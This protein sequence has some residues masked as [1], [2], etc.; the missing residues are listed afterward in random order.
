M[1]LIISAAAIAVLLSVICVVPAN[2]QAEA[3]SI[4]GVVSDSSGNLIPGITVTAT[5]RDT[6]SVAKSMTNKDGMYNFANLQPGTY[7]VLVSLIGF[8]NERAQKP[9]KTGE[10]AQLNFTMKI[11]L[12]ATYPK[13]FFMNPEEQPDSRLREKSRP[14]DRGSMVIPPRQDRTYR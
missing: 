8:G 2:G 6:K 12:R 5:N 1:K 4:S 10:S 14:A 7:D 3:A 13:N 11:V 9:L